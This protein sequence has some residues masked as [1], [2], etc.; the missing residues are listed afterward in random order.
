MSDESSGLLKIK[1]QTPSNNSSEDCNFLE[2]DFLDKFES[3][4]SDLIDI[5]SKNETKLET[6]L[7]DFEEMLK[8]MVSDLT[9]RIIS[10]IKEYIGT[11][12]FY[13]LLDQLF[14]D[15]LEKKA[16]FEEDDS[17]ITRKELLGIINKFSS[18]NNANLL[19]YSLDIDQLETFLTKI[20]FN[21]KELM[22]KN[23]EKL[24]SDFNFEEVCKIQKNNIDELTFF[25]KNKL[26][27][28]CLNEIKYQNDSMNKTI[29]E[30]DNYIKEFQET[31]SEQPKTE[32]VG[33]DLIHEEI[34]EKLKSNEFQNNYEISNLVKILPKHKFL[35]YYSEHKLFCCSFKKYQSISETS[36]NL[37]KHPL[38]NIEIDE[39][40]GLICIESN[41]DTFEFTSFQIN[42]DGGFEINTI[43]TFD[44]IHIESYQFLKGNDKYHL[45]LKTKS[46]S[47]LFIN[48][49][50]WEIEFS[51]SNKEVLSIH[52]LDPDNLLL[53]MEKYIFYVF[54]LKSL[55]ITD[56]LNL[57]LALPTRYA[58]TLSLNFLPKE[59]YQSKEYVNLRLNV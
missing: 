49:K 33:E 29:A 24:H 21:V 54:S 58:K 48:K 11:H 23:Y 25:Y 57:L 18:L 16:K 44:E 31:T 8:D 37:T 17:N 6:R 12:T 56:K 53:R 38:K 28:K 55:D 9:S 39:D 3:I 22:I 45:V 34:I 47:Y 43:R 4:I 35:I 13:Y 40:L 27:V 1:E 50:T 26:N 42:S 15:F 52:Q 19:S 51:I 32:K 46:Y 14:T 59:K 30:L 5:E 10:P 2:P 7:E 36:Y 41:R 20:N